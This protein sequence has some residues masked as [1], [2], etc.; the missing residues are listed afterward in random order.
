MSCNDGCKFLELMGRIAELSQEIK[1]P[2]FYDQLILLQARNVELAQEN[3]KMRKALTKI[4]DVDVPPKAAWYMRS[5]AK[6]ALA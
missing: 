2:F 6:K 4:R 1:K 3:E 5:L